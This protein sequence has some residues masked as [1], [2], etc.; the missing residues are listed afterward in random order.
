MADD[1]DAELLAL[2]GDASDEETSPKLTADS[3]APSRSRSPQPTTTM[4]RKGTGKSSRRS[5]KSRKG[6]GDGAGYVFL[7]FICSFLGP[8]LVESVVF[9]EYN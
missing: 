3:P 7:R 1:L 9:G 2:A 6:D 5:R 8:C 4:A